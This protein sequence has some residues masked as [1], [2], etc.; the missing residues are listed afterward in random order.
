VIFV[1]VDRAGAHYDLYLA[2]EAG[3]LLARGTVADGAEGLARFHELVDAQIK[4][5]TDVVVG[6]ETAHGLFVSALMASGYQV[7]AVN[8]SSRS[9]YRESHGP[10]EAN[11]EPDD[12]R[13]LAEVVRTERKNHRPLAGDSA[14]VDAVKVL[15]RAHQTL[16][17]SRARQADQLS[18]LLREFY[19]AA[20]E[21]FDE[22]ARADAL[23]VLAIAPTPELGR[24]LSQAKIA[25]ALRRGG[26]ERQVEEQ[27]ASVQA[28]LRSKQL[29]APPLVAGA[30][31]EVVRSLVAV[32]TAMT[33]EVGRLEGVMA[34]N[35]DHPPS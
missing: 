21:A 12:A 14:G 24:S 8:P 26:R 13:V 28:A 34:S 32:M 30:M 15:A 6:T 17:R 5:P 31:A 27:A 25:A 29:A 33:A 20:L 16:V 9:R 11:A 1:G 7:Y 19:P 22:L 35:F 4:E 3:N 23:A 10:S 18:S 2:D